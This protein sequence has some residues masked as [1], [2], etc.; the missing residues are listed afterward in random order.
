MT[1]R[2]ERHVRVK[3]FVIYERQC[4]FLNSMA[5]AIANATKSFRNISTKG[6]ARQYDDSVLLHK[7]LSRRWNLER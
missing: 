6:Y 4:S 7:F 1:N 5:E 2:A 3:G